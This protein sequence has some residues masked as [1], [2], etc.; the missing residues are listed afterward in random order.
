MTDKPVTGVDVLRQTVNARNKSPHAL[1]LIAREVGSV[2]AS[3]LE[4]FAAGKADL[5]VATLK[6]L[7]PVLH[8]NAEYDAELNLLRSA[9]KAEPIPLG[10]TP[11]PYKPKPLNFTP[12][13]PPVGPR[14]VN[15]E[16]PKV[17]AGRP[18]WLGGWT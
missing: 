11:P 6:A 3:T 9:N 14:P 12:G 7:T 13:L 5:D 16:K 18:G 15:P 17:K 10:I 1:S 4:D 2:S 8:P